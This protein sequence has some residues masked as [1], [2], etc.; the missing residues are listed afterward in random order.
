MKS[1]FF[2]FFEIVYEIKFF[3]TLTLMYGKCEKFLER[4]CQLSLDNFPHFSRKVKR[5]RH[6]VSCIKMVMRR[7]V[8]SLDAILGLWISMTMKQKT[9][10]LQ[11]SF[12]IVVLW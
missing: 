11:K 12:I 9:Q 3:V 1:V 10:G 4:I 6:D 7:Y 8:K 5:S 2:L